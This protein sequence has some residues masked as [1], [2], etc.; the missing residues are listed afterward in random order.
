MAI[1]KPLNDYI[2]GH[3]MAIGK[4]GLIFVSASEQ[5]SEW[6]SGYPRKLLKRFISDIR[7]LAQVAVHQIVIIL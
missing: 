4:R 1:R 7:F 2:D 5:D 3:M 6:Y